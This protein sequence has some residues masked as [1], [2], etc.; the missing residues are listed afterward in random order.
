MKRKMRGVID[1]YGVSLL[2]ALIGAFFFE[3]HQDEQQHAKQ[4]E[5]QQYS[6]SLANTNQ[7]AAQEATDASDK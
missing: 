6:Q 7:V 3:A 2:L 1:P 5:Q 4:Q